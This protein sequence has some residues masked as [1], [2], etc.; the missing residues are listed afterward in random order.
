MRFAVLGRPALQGVEDFLH[1]QNGVDRIVRI[2]RVG[3][4]PVHG[5]LVIDVAHMAE[6]HPHLR[7]LADDRHVG[8]T[9]V[10]GQIAGA[11]AASPV[12]L[13]LVMVDRAHLD[14][15]A[16]RPDGDVSLELDSRVLDG[17]EGLDV[18]GDRALHVVDAQA[19]YPFLARR[20]VGLA[21]GIGLV[22]GELGEVGLFARVGGVNMSTEEKLDSGA[23]A[24]H[25][26]QRV[27]PIRL[28]LLEARGEPDRLVAV[29]QEVGD[30]ALLPR[31]TPDVDQIHSQLLE[32]P[33]V[34]R[35]PDFLSMFV[36]AR[37]PFHIST[38]SS[39]RV[40]SR[41]TQ[42]TKR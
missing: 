10:G 35:R 20:G 31:G 15:T 14:L 7:G 9:A 42:P 4:R 23:V 8:A 1:L 40:D 27:E 21:P 17:V 3:R 12:V 24:L 36:H 34:D 22:G 41:R 11:A 37:R 30:L 16:H 19:V 6:N 18:A 29:A 33:F 5:D 38:P 2:G 25:G 26:S 39:G 28:E 32:T 13:A